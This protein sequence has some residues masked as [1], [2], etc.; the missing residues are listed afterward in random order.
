MNTIPTPKIQED[1]TPTNSEQVATQTDGTETGKLLLSDLNALT[2]KSTRFQTVM[3][4]EEIRMKHKELETLKKEYCFSVFLLV[5]PLFFSKKLILS[6]LIFLEYSSVARIQNKK[7][8]WAVVTCKCW[9]HRSIFGKVRFQH[10]DTKAT[11]SQTRY[12]QRSNQR[13]VPQIRAPLPCLWNYSTCMN[14]YCS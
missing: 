1:N 11:A 2:Y 4:T 10:T 8:F 5:F 13:R 12:D 14:L 9:Y 7:R 6:L 3:L